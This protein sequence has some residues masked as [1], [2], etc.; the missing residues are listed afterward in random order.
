MMADDVIRWNRATGLVY[1]QILLAVQH[2]APDGALVISCRTRPLHWVVDIIRFLFSAFGSVTAVNPTYQ[3]RRPFAY[4]VCRSFRMAAGVPGTAERDDALRR[5]HAAVAYLEESDGTICALLVR[6]WIAYRSMGCWYMISG[7]DRR[8][9][10]WHREHPAALWGPRRAHPG[11]GVRGRP[12]PVQRRLA[13]QVSRHPREL[14][15]SDHQALEGCV[16]CD[17]HLLCADLTIWAQRP[18][19]ALPAQSTDHPQAGG[20]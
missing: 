11:G 10:A 15:E 3:A 18:R 4:I 16:R 14:R 17:A 6:I 1:A 19:K 7:A 8:A 9:R 20:R 5:L 2:L 12:V 13:E